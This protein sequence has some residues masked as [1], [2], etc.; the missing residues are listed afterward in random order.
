MYGQTTTALVTEVEAALFLRLKPQTIRQWRTLKR[1]PRYFK[2]G[3]AVRYKT[4]DLEQFVNAGA[5]LM[6]GFT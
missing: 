5:L 6:E 1:G 3:G 2:V 4:A